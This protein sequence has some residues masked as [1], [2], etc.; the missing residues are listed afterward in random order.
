M[1]ERQTKYDKSVLGL[2]KVQNPHSILFSY[3]W[4]WNGFCSLQR[5]MDLSVDSSGEDL[6]LLIWYAC[7]YMWCKPIYK[8]AA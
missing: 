3:L 8:I 2:Q 7:W 5:T 6:E 1:A 4:I